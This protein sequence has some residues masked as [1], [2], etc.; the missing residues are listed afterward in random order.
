MVIPRKY[1]TECDENNFQ[2]L[3]YIIYLHNLLSQNDHILH[4]I[5]QYDFS[6]NFMLY[7]NLPNINSIQI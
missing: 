7:I 1:C 6:Y 4:V 5:L 2:C 3:L